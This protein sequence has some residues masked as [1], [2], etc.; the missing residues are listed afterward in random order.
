K[1][2]ES[3]M[4]IIVGMCLLN[5]VLVL[6]QNVWYEIYSGLF[7]QTSTKFFQEMVYKKAAKVELA[8][9]ENPDF[10][11]KYVKA[12]NETA[13]RADKVATSCSGV[14]F[15]MIRFFA[16]GALLMAIDPMFLV[17]LVF[18]LITTFFVK[19]RKK[20]DFDMYTENV[21]ANRKCD[22]TRR[23]FYLAEYSKEMRL[24]NIHVVMAKRFAAAIKD[25]KK[26]I[27]K[28]G[29]RSAVWNYL[30]E[31]FME[32]FTLM[33]A[34]AYAVYCTLAAGTMLYGDCL[35]VIS[36]I[37]SLSWSIFGST[38]SLLAFEEHALYIENLRH[39]LDYDPSIKT[40]AD[41]I[42]IAR[43]ALELRDVS[44]RYD[45]T[46]KDVLKHV[47]IKCGPKEKIA[48]VGHNGAGKST[49]V[50]LMLRLY[51]PTAGEIRLN[52]EDIRRYSVEEYRGAFSA[53]F[54]DFHVFSLSVSE[55]V[56][57]RPIAE[58]DGEKVDYALERSGSAARVAEMPQG[59][60]TVLTREFD[61]KGEVLSGG[62]TQ[63]LAIAHAFTKEN[64]FVILDEPTSA[65]DPIAEHEM[66]KN[67]TEACAECGMIFISHR[68][69]SAVMADRIY[70]L[71]NGEVAESGTHEELMAM[72]GKYADMF[73]KQSENYVGTEGEI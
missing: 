8:C 16:N 36:A 13:S 33:G 21:A 23:V 67:M 14:V 49:L 2:F 61:K 28:Y 43:G 31:I 58:G 48:L 70:L 68:L 59:K 69:S 35:V 52:G 9:Y 4:P 53:V 47:N 44:F 64:L 6:V 12:L 15:E 24:G 17:F 38:D 50:K 54:Q 5:I 19:K 66:Y 20:A 1:T 45:G 7:Y 60:Q 73:R 10:Y 27:R 65:L 34:T 55:N 18:P 72:G 42:P 26:V 41:H 37:S 57:L 32:V 46:E 56:L 11:D 3:L 71:E 25:A 62:E 39:F 30:I 40:E 51:D 22:Y 63:K 29:F